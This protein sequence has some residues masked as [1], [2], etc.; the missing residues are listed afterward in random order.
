[1]FGEPA[2]CI[3]VFGAAGPRY[4]GTH[5]LY[6]TLANRLRDYLSTKFKQF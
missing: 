6:H 2:V 4:D 1:M 5:R 3:L